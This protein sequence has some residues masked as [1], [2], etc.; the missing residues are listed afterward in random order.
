MFGFFGFINK[1]IHVNMSEW[2]KSQV[3]TQVG[4]YNSNN[5][6]TTI[7]DITFSCMSYGII[8]R[9]YTPTELV[10]VNLRWSEKLDSWVI[11]QIVKL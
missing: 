10:V 7:D 2:D 1:Y 11:F 4:Y 9:K 8:N 5:T 3:I 6:F